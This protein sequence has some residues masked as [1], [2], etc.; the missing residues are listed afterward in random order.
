MGPDQQECL[1]TRATG[2]PK[3]HLHESNPLLSKLTHF[4]A[5]NQTIWP[6]IDG[7]FCRMRTAPARRDLISEGAAAVNVALLTRGWAARYKVAAEGQ[8]QI[9]SF[10]VPGDVFPIH[11]LPKGKLDYAVLALTPCQIAICSVESLDRA[12][13]HNP[14]IARAFW[15]LSIQDKNILRMWLVNLGVRCAHQRI[16]HLLCELAERLRMANQ[17]SGFSFDFPPTQQQLAES[18][19]LTAVHTNRILQQLRAEKLIELRGRRLTILNPEGLRQTGD[20]D[21]DYLSPGM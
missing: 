1:R 6:A 4:G 13:L 16:A 20:F 21:P 9:L 2:P 14:E 10:L 17:I 19:G 3:H 8:R 11:P 12:L 7:L 15:W 5:F 18:Q